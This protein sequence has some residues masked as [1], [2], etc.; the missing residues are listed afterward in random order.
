MRGVAR[1][2]GRRAGWRSRRRPPSP[3]GSRSSAAE[4]PR[5]PRSA[6]SRSRSS[7]TP[8]TRAVRCA[9]AAGDEQVDVGRHARE[10]ADDDLVG[11]DAA[12]DG[13]RRRDDGADGASGHLVEDRGDAR[14][15]G[16]ARVRARSGGR[17]CAACASRIASTRT[18][19]SRSKRAGAGVPESSVSVVSSAS[20]PARPVAASSTVYGV[21]N[22]SRRS[23]AAGS[24]E[25]PMTSVW[26]AG[27]QRA[28]ARR[29]VTPPTRQRARTRRGC[30]R[31]PRGRAR[32]S[33]SGRTPRRCRAA[34]ARRRARGA[35]RRAR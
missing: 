16:R 3:R 18:R 32:S 19:R 4:T 25:A 21:S 14:R 20:V 11:G 33:A 12:G 9:V 29:A 28:R 8:R 5:R 34:R 35:S 22:R 7:G 10:V 27:A 13:R 15:R 30:R 2:V 6:G 17:R 23:R 24:S 31:A 1:R 26:P